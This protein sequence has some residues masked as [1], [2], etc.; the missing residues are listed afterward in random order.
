LLT[1][2]NTLVYDI[3]NE[4]GQTPFQLAMNTPNVQAFLVLQMLKNYL[5]K[6]EKTAELS[7][8][9]KSQLQHVQKIEDKVQLEE[10]HDWNKTLQELVTM[11]TDFSRR[12]RTPLVRYSFL[13]GPARM[14]D[15][16]DYLSIF[17]GSC[18][19][20]YRK[21]VDRINMPDLEIPSE[22]LF[23]SIKTGQNLS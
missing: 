22:N 10:K 16:R 12:E 20:I 13:T 4:V 8:I 3:K 14:A 9:A 11:A 2:E 21:L 15:L 19:D 5:Q 17:E 1:N 6:N 7:D 18:T 23:T